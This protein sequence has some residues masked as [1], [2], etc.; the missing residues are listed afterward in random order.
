[1]N[2]IYYLFHRCQLFITWFA[3]IVALVGT[4]TVA[5][6]PVSIPLFTPLF[7][8][9][10]AGIFVK[11][12]VFAMNEMSYD[13]KWRYWAFVI[14]RIPKHAL[15]GCTCTWWLKYNIIIL[16]KNK[17]HCKYHYQCKCKHLYTIHI[18]INPKVSSRKKLSTSS[19]SSISH[20]VS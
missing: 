8:V 9:L 4:F 1:M 6:I 7:L 11:K 15:R 3:L 20:S 10:L 19:P 16:L 5:F 13:I 14:L 17:Y 18:S 2:I 12:I